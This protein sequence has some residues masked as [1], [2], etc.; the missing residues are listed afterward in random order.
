MYSEQINPSS[1]LVFT[2]CKGSLRNNGNKKWG[3]NVIARLAEEKAIQAS[4][5]LSR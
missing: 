1:A 5:S 3:N 4:Q 2:L